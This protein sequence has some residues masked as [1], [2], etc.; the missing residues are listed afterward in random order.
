MIDS[1]IAA[2]LN[3]AGGIA[4]QRGAPNIRSEHLLAALLDDKEAADLVKKAGGDAQALRHAI[5]ATDA[6][7]KQS[8]APSTLY[9][10]RDLERIFQG[11]LQ[12]ARQLNRPKID[13]GSVLAAMALAVDTEAGIAL[14]SAGVTV[15]ALAATISGAPTQDE[16]GSEDDPL[17][18]FCVDLTA[19]ARDGDID[20]VIGRDDEIRRVIQVLTRRTKSNPVLIG[21]AG[22]G[23]TAIVEGLAQRIVDGEVP[24]DLS[25]K[26]VMS[27]DMGALVAGASMHGEFEKRLKSVI[28]AVKGS[29]GQVILFID[30]LHLLIGA[31]R[32]QGAMVAANLLKPSLARGDLHCVGATTL[33]EYRRYLEKDAALT[34]RFQPLFVDE[35][36]PEDTLA[37]LRGIKERY[38]THHGIK[39]TDKALVAA[40]TYA[41]RYL[42]ERRLPDA[43]IDLADEAASRVRMRANSKTRTT[44]R[45]RPPDHP[46]PDRAPGH[47]RGGDGGLKATGRRDRQG[48]GRSR[49]TVRR[50]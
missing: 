43:A 6:P 8:G 49:R 13:T 32:T 46:A 42:T 23:K 7:A 17:Q 19:M 25:D 2:A 1:K 29:N 34:R 26:R 37:I 4:I 12:I 48:A 24:D 31:G 44:R 9:I 15:E 27:L 36:S 28:D 5:D 39:I 18:A 20:P 3:G 30:E 22:V 41:K 40:T 14:R 11:A 33:D 10:S 38:E 50:A 35:P 45:A 21:D 47:P 16:D